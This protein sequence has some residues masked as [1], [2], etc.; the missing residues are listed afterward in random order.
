MVFNHS[1]YQIIP[2]RNLE[3]GRICAQC[4]LAKFANGSNVEPLT[5]QQTVDAAEKFVETVAADLKLG[6]TPSLD[7]VQVMWA[8][9]VFDWIVDNPEAYLSVLRASIIERA[10][11]ELSFKK[12]ATNR[13]STI[14]MGSKR[15]MLTIYNKQ[16]EVEHQ[17][18][19][20]EYRQQV[21]EKAEGRLRAEVRLAGRGW[22]KYLGDESPTLRQVLDFLKRD[23]RK[24]LTLDWARLTDGWSSQNIESDI[25]QLIEKFG[26]TKGRQVGGMLALVRA[27][28]VPSYRQI[29]K[30][31]PSNF[32]NFRL[33]LRTAGIAM[34]DS[35]GLPKLSIPWF[36]FGDW[37]V[38]RYWSLWHL[39]ATISDSLDEAEHN[40]V[41]EIIGLS[42]EIPVSLTPWE[43]AA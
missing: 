8:D 11:H 30:P 31:S 24:P 38:R 17:N 1:R 13:G 5:L 2:P 21:L 19:H 18:L 20:G 40:E 22:A 42:A 3:S 34:I 39:R 25:S 6:Y 36:D 32:Y 27:I 35:T 4:S 14:N 26:T 7:K 15:H 41:G 43:F 23:G 37:K 9:I 16:A 10:N 29:C 28:G 33:A 12:S